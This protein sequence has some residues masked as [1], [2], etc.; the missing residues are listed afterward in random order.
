MQ[1][2]MQTNKTVAKDKKSESWVLYHMKL[3][4]ENMEIGN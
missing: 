4:T 1:K 3:A 2:S